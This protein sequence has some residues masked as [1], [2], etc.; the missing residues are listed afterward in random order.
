MSGYFWNTVSWLFHQNA[1]VC[2]PCHECLWLG[3]EITSLPGGAPSVPLR[4]PR[5][6]RVPAPRSSENAFSLDAASWKVF[7][8]HARIRKG[9]ED[10]SHCCIQMTSS[11]GFP[12]PV[13][14]S[15]ICQL[16]NSSRLTVKRKPEYYRCQKMFKILNELFLILQT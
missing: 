7:C 16:E 10:M 6:V 3:Y 5:L 11:Q 12:D 14:S 1:R 4:N 15:T 13:S 2:L 8:R 9:L